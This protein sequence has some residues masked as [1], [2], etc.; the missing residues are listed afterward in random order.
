[1]A[2]LTEGRYPG[3]F[4]LS[5][6]PGTLSRDAGTV[7]V[8]ANTTLEPGTVLGRLS[9]T[10]HYAPYDDA[11]TD[12]TETA[13]G[14][15]YGPRL[16]NE[17]ALVVSEDATIVTRLAEVMTG[18]LEWGAGVDE[19]GGAADLAALLILVR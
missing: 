13:A 7:D 4:L 12:G 19:A 17:T 11:N 15:L 1:M 5:E 16:I 10:G 6:A 9:A 3:E 8:P 18:S 14:I 2:A